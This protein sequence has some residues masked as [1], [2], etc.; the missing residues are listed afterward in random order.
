MNHSL[1]V[2]FI[3]PFK[4]PLLLLSKALGAALQRPKSC[5][6]SVLKVE[7]RVGHV[8]RALRSGQI[9]GGQGICVWDREG[10]DPASMGWQ[11]VAQWSHLQLESTDPTMP[12]VPRGHRKR[13]QSCPLQEAAALPGQALDD[14]TP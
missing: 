1:S 6:F 10:V 11:R 4:Y 8:C 3:F 9:C 12:A 14:A 13:W 2:P 7:S 5:H